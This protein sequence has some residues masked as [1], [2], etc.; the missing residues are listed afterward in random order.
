MYMQYGTNSINVQN[1]QN[2]AHFPLLWDCIVQC[3]A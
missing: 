2:M 3:N 1:T